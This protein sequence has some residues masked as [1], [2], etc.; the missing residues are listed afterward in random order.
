MSGNARFIQGLLGGVGLTALALLASGCRAGETTVTVAA[1]ETTGIAVSGL[2]TV[3][4]TPDV[5]RINLGVEVTRNTVAEAR[6][7]AAEAMESVRAS[8]KSN[9]VEDKD[10]RTQY[11]N[12][13]PQY[14]P[15]DVRGQSTITG[16]T[17]SNQVQVTVRRIDNASKVLDD[18]VD[19][20]GDAARVN[21][22]SFEVDDPTEFQNEAR[23]LAV[24]NARTKAEQLADAAGV[25]LGPVRSLSE[26]VSSG[27]VPVFERVAQA[28][29]ALDASTP[30]DPGQSEIQLVVN[31][32]YDVR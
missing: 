22:I 12:I 31:V 23:E 4:A 32:T 2:G 30:I 5:A 15:T 28:G 13:Y 17:V 1:P 26:S 25:E 7:A 8:V 19:A 6:T 10:I 14:G 29:G 24:Q 20:G 16:Y 11:V 21:G 3:N 9:G 27:P 18:A